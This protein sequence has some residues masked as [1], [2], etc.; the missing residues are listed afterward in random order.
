MHSDPAQFLCELQCA[1]D[2]NVRSSGPP[3]CTGVLGSHFHSKLCTSLDEHVRADMSFANLG[4]GKEA[5]ALVEQG[6]PFHVVPR[7]CSGNI[8]IGSSGHCTPANVRVELASGL[9]QE[10]GPLPWFVGEDSLPLPPHPSAQ[11]H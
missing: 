9:F 3:M 11:I 10:L 8:L 1:M 2:I 5:K 6:D 7:E 4:V